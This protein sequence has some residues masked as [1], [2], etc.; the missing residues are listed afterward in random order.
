MGNEVKELRAF[1]IGTVVKTISGVVGHVDGFAINTAGETILVIKSGKYEAHFS[2]DACSP[3]YKYTYVHV[4]NV[5][6][7]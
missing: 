1:K 7:V 5:S 2:L 6:L 3:T 4:C